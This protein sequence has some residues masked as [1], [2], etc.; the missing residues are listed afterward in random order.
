MKTLLIKH[1]LNFFGLLMAVVLLGTSCKKSKDDNKESGFPRNVTIEYKVSSSSGLNKTEITYSNE[2]GGMTMVENA[3][4]PFTKKIDRRLTELTAIGLGI[5]SDI[6]GSLNLEILVNGKSVK[7]QTFTMSP[8][9]S[10]NI[11]HVFYE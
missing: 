3:S 7:A 6:P 9:I 2:T 5:A 8:I 11:Q 10:G 4:L 1:P